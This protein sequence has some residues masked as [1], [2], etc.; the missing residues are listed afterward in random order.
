MDKITLKTI[1]RSEAF[2]YMAAE[3]YSPDGVIA[4]LADECER[5]LIRV[6]SPKYTY[7]VFGI[8][9]NDGSRVRLS[10][11]PLILEGKDISSLLSGCHSAVLMCATVGAAADG[12]I[13][14]YQAEDMTKAVI[15]DSFASTAVEQVCAAFDDMLREKYP[16]KFI[17][18]RFSPGYGDLPISVQK[19]F[20]NILNA[21]RLTGICL[22]SAGMLTPVKSVTAVCGI[23]DIP[24]PK[25]Q[26]GCAVC[27]M[28]ENCAYRKRGT[29]CEF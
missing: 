11:C 27:R 29:R 12:L 2:R 1:D 18:W 15:T 20:L 7:R 26:R 16:D 21:M 14:R 24:L 19:D 3:G 22:N 5:E 13:R 25:K 9:D 8:S 28:R 23:S 4:E 10:G 6:I 17:T